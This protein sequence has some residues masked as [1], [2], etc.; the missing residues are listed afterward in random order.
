MEEAL[1]LM[2]HRI[3]RSLE[4]ENEAAGSGFVGLNEQVDE[5]RLHR[6][7]VD[8]EFA[9]AV[10]GILR[11]MFRPVECRLAC[12]HCAVGAARFQFARYQPKHR[13]MAQLVMV[14]QVFIAQRYAMHTLRQERFRA[15]L[16]PL[17]SATIREA[18]RDLP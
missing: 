4:I 8:G 12:A 15:V 14:V 2:A 6:L 17:L 7:A 9:V 10:L 3:V 18:G 11:R 1:L 13:I 5:Q 16:H